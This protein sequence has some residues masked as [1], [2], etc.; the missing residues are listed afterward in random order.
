MLSSPLPLPA[1]PQHLPPP[2]L[3][4]SL[5]QQ[6]QP[7]R[8]RARAKHLL[9]GRRR[10]ERRHVKRLTAHTSIRVSDR[11]YCVIVDGYLMSHDMC[12]IKAS[13]PGYW[14]L[15]QGHGYLELFCQ[16]YL[17]ED[18]DRGFQ[19]VQSL[20]RC[21]S[22]RSDIRLQNLHHIARNLPS[23]HERSKPV[24]VSSFLVS[25]LSTPYPKVPNLLRQCL[26]NL[27]H[28]SNAL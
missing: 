9:M 3:P 1:K 8:Q 7:K 6:R 11:V 16:R 28:L 19:Y 21:C 22:I 5:R 10:R 25:W 24:S 23:L 27:G 4:P 13:A 18:C 2:R 20:S 17:W 12:S 26:S 15:Q 14:Y